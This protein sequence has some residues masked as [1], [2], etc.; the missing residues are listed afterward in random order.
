MSFSFFSGDIVFFCVHSSSDTSGTAID[1][2][3]EGA[4]LLPALGVFPFSF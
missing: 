1:A 4:V 3:S 2:E